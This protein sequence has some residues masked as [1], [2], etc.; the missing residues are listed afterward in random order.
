MDSLQHFLQTGGRTGF[1][2]VHH[3]ISF[4]V[5]VHP[6]H[7][8]PQAKEPTIPQG[9]LRRLFPAGRVHFRRSTKVEFLSMPKDNSRKRGRISPSTFFRHSRS[10]SRIDRSNRSSRFRS[11][12]NNAGGRVFPFSRTNSRRKPIPSPRSD[13]PGHSP[14]W[15]TSAAVHDIGPKTGKEFGASGCPFPAA[16]RLHPAHPGIVLPRFARQSNESGNGP[17]H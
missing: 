17:P 7:L 1:V 10:W 14:H 16:T 3:I 2:I 5:L 12:P 13:A 6:V 15:M 4:L 11:T 9:Q 8:S